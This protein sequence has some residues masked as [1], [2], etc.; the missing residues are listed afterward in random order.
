MVELGGGF[1]ARTVDAHAALQRHNPLPCHFVVVEA[2]PTHFE[3]AK[4]HMR[5]NGIDPEAHWLINALVSTDNLPKLFML[6]EGY[7]GNA[8]VSEGDITQLVKNLQE[9]NSTDNALQG[10]ML[11]GRCGVQQPY[12]VANGIDAASCWLSRRAVVRS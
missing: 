10:L 12:S 7:Y 11:N 8:V 1:A 3:W 4:R 9:G 5:A 6:G 2:E